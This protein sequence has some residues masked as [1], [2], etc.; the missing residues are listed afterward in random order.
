MKGYQ[1]QLALDFLE[2]SKAVK[3]AELVQECVDV[4]EAGTPLVKSEGLRSVREL[5][6]LFPGKEVET[7]LK[8]ADTGYMEAEMAFKAGADITTVLAACPHETVQGALDTGRDY[9]K[10]V[11]VDFIGCKSVL[12]RYNELK[13]LELKIEFLLVHAGIDQQ[14]RGKSPLESLAQLKERSLTIAVAGGL[15]A[16]TIPK[17]MALGATHLIVGGASSFFQ[18][19]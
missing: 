1:L 19:S 10:K 17:V 4:L 6:R 8:T 2:L 14:M 12:E 15:N 3:T 5:K 16:L 13:A 11:M 9:K 18:L 7:D